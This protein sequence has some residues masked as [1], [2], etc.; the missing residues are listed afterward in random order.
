MTRSTDVQLEEIDE[1]ISTV[2]S[3]GPSIQCLN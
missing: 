2:P 1:V 3:A